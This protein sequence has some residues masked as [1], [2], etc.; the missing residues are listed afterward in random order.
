MAVGQ[1]AAKTPAGK[2]PQATSAAGLLLFAVDR[3]DADN[4]T[5]NPIVLYQN[6]RFID[7]M[8]KDENEAAYV[9]FE[10]KYL[11][12]GQTYRL[13]SGGGDAGT[14]T[15]K[16]RSEAGIGLTAQ[17]ELQTAAKLGGEVRA[18][19]T[20]SE[21]IGRKQSSRR[22]PT[23]EERAAAVR[24]AKQAYRQKNVPAGFLANLA[25]LNLTA[26]DLDA[27]GTFELIGSF[28]AKG[29]NDTSHCLFLIVESQKGTPAIALTWYKQGSEATYESRR[30][31]D[32]IDID[33]DGVSE[34]VTTTGYYESTDYSIY[35]KT[36]G[37]WRSV[38]QGGH[39]GV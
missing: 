16:S 38:Y 5:V 39:F 3:Y 35:K 29:A 1:S 32:H 30:F 4:I 13:I 22:P 19:A 33:G 8:P 9:A 23:P 17:A 24:L 14:V 12:A 21:L 27:D 34:V 20:D 2:P 36:K 37:V 10:K 18:L 7:P 11:R 28:E 6:G 31:V 15:V 25:T 26:C